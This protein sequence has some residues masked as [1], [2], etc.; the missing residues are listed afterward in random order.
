M[1]ALDQDDPRYGYARHK[2]YATAE[3]LA[4]I[5]SH[6]LSDAHRRTLPPATLLD[7]LNDATT[8]ADEQLARN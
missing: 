3:H 6:G 1:V 8:A 4:A 2:G 5:R 7:L